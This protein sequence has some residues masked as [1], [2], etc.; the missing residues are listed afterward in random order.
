VNHRS[1][2]FHVWTPTISLAFRGWL[3]RA[4]L[5]RYRRP[6]IA[7]QGLLWRSWQSATDAAQ[8]GLERRV[9]DLTDAVIGPLRKN[10]TSIDSEAVN[11]EH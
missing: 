10:G 6:L 1:R 11:I 7:C 2:L 3:R 4:C 8:A 5:D 9:E